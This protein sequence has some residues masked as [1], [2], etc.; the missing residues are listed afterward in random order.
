MRRGSPSAHNIF[1]VATTL[2]TA[3]YVYFLALEKIIKQFPEPVVN[4]AVEI[5]TQQMIQL[6][7][8]QGLDIHWRDTF[9][10]PTEEEY[11]EMI[12]RKTGG[13]FNMGVRMMELFAQNNQ[14]DFSHLVQLMGQFFQIR[15]DYANLFSHEVRTGVQRVCLM[16][17]S[18]F[19][20]HTITVMTFLVCR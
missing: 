12:K 7:R 15:D 11:I 20:E 8:G 1:G 4:Q 13:L 2:N 10:C 5:F 14:R 9:Q 3:N 6:H 16:T 19:T 18:E 17:D